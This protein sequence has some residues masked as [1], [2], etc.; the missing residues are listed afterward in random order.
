MN[1]LIIS[2]IID[3][4]KNQKNKFKKENSCEILEI[5]KW[6]AYSLP[7]YLDDFDAMVIDLSFEDERNIGNIQNIYTTIS[8]HLD[9]FLNAPKVVIMICGTIETEIFSEDMGNDKISTFTYQI[10]SNVFSNIDKT[11]TSKGSCYRLHEGFSKSV[12]DYFGY[13]SNYSLMFNFTVEINNKI[14]KERKIAIVRNS[15]KIISAEISFMNGILIILPGYQQNSAKRVIDVIAR[16]TLDYHQKV[17]KKIFDPSDKPDWVIKYQTEEHLKIEEEV[18]KLNANKEKYEK[19]VALLYGQ[20]EPLEEFVATTLEDIGLTVESKQK[21]YSIDLVACYDDKYRFIFEITG[22]TDKIKQQDKVDQILQYRALREK[23]GTLTNE[24]MILIANTYAHLDL[25]ERKD[26]INFT[27]HA[28]SLYP[29][30]ETTVMTTVDLYFLWKAVKENKIS[31][32]EAIKRIWETT[33]E[34]KL[35]DEINPLK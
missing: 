31:K 21:G 12:Y 8:D 11:A 30:I 24:K 27:P 7:R 4:S 3:I 29:S 18:A 5:V 6:N 14:L 19:I 20:N 2:N 32:E 9:A 16:M 23:E 25:E 28:L 26:K 1:L 33:L 13:F 22:K 35:P 17:Q 34:F 10:L 15:D